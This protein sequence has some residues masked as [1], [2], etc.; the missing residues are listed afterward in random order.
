MLARRQSHII[1]ANIVFL[2]CQLDRQ[3]PIKSTIRRYGKGVTQMDD[4]KEKELYH[5]YKQKQQYRIYSEILQ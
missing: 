4:Q 3:R 2:D 5:Q 1:L